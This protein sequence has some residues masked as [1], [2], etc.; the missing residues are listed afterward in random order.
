MTQ[1]FAYSAS[2]GPSLT[3]VAYNDSRIHDNFYEPGEG[4][5]N[6]T[7]TATRTSD[8]AT[9]TT[10]TWASGAYTLSLPAGTYT[11][12]ASGTG[13]GTITKNNIVI[14]TQNVEQDFVPTLPAYVVGRYIAYGDSV[15]DGNT[16]APGASDDAA[17]APDKTAL[18]PGVP[19]SFANYTSYV[20]GINAIVV[21]IAGAGTVQAS[22]FTFKIGNSATP[23]SWANA[24]ATSGFLVR[25]GAGVNGSTRIEITWADNTIRNQWMQVTIAANAHTNLTIPDVFY[26]GNAIGSSGTTPASGA[27]TVSDQTVTASNFTG[28]TSPASITNPYDYNRD[29]RVDIS[30]EL[31]ARAESNASIN[32]VFF[33]PTDPSDP[34]T[35]SGAVPDM[36]PLVSD[37]TAVAKKAAKKT[38]ANVNKELLHRHK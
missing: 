5:G 18:L 34:T 11:V 9:F 14:S 31:I 2:S 23:T 8:N 1:D 3:G 32:L 24:P 33:T 21:D 13:L 38:A 35:G 17:I 12:T 25:P 30:D 15:F 7:I 10:T 36:T 20:K 27:I 28:F 19:A 4:L 29:G 6:I 37:P 26:F 16:P 22:D